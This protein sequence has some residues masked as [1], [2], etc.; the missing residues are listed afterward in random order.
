[1]LWWIIGG[2]GAIA[3]VAFAVYV[4]IGWQLAYRDDDR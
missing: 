4:A 3:V 1:M 2:A